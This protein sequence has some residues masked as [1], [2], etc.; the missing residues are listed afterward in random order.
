M[1]AALCFDKPFVLQAD[2]SHVGAGAILMQEDEQGVDRV[3]N[4]FSKMF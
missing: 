2:A 4:F 1:L 3:V